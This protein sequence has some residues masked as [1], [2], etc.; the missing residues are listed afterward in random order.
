M[1]QALSDR[2]KRHFEAVSRPGGLLIREWG[3]C[4]GPPL[5]DVFYRE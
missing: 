2:L 1:I 4:Y 3:L 5:T